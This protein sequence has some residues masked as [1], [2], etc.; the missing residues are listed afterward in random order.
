VSDANS[1]LEQKWAQEEANKAPLQKAYEKVGNK[2]T[3]EEK[4]NPEKLSS[5][6]L[7]QL[8]EPTGWRILI[9]PYRGQARTEGGI[10]LTEKTVERQQIATVLG[11]VLKTGELAY[12]DEN[13]FPTG[14]WCEAGDWVLFGRYAGSR[15]EIEGGEVKILNDDEIIAKVTDPEAILHNY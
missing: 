5:D 8:P 9:L 7:N 1:A 11:Y 10:Y 15:F 2:K 14:P 3:D 4:L 12:Q 13:K 6:L